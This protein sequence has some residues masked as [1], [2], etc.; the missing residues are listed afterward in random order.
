MR[1]YLDIESLANKLQIHSHVITKD[2]I[3]TSNRDI[4]RYTIHESQL[5]NMPLYYRTPEE[6]REKE[7]VKAM[8]IDEPDILDAAIAKSLKNSGS[9]HY[10]QISSFLFRNSRENNQ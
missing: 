2:G 3:Y 4:G 6:V 7:F 5:V 1:D 9:L 8:Y 10:G